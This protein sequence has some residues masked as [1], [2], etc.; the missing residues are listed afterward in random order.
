M[1]K[2]QTTIKQIF[3][4]SVEDQT[5]WQDTSATV[6]MSISPEGDLV[7]PKYKLD[8]L[9]KKNIDLVALVVELVQ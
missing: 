2:T 7:I 4:P 6:L 3:H 1:M 5:Q 9:K 8:E